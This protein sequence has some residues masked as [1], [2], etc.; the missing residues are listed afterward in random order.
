MRRK[1]I[2]E[3][4]GEY[5]RDWTLPQTPGGRTLDLTDGGSFHLESDAPTV[6]AIAERDEKLLDLI[7]RM[8][9]AFDAAAPEAFSAFWYAKEAGA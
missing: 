2:D 7:H 9:T 8:A 1:Y 6:A 4:L 3:R 5:L